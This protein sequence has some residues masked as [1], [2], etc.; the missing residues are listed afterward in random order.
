MKKIQ[1]IENHGKCYRIR[2]EKSRKSAFF[3]Y[4]FPLAQLEI[5]NILWYN[6]IRW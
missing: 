5:L 4:V 6:E 1:D 3:S 2:G